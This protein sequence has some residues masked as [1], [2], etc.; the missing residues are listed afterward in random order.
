MVI[1]IRIEIEFT[2]LLASLTVIEKQLGVDLK[3]ERNVP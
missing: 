2:E 1:Q 3:N